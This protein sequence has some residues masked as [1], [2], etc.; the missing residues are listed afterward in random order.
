MNTNASISKRHDPRFND[1]EP[2]SHSGVPTSAEPTGNGFRIVHISD[3]HLSRQFYREH[4][5]SF[6]LLLKS[7]LASGFDH[8][9]ITGDIVST[10]EEDDYYLA[11]EI[12]GTLDLLDSKRL[13]VVP[14]NH[15]IFGGPHRAVD[16]LSFPKYI[17]NVDYA[18]NL[19]LF[20]VAFGET[21]ETTVSYGG[22]SV[23]PFVKKVG[24][25]SIIGLN[26]ILPWSLRRNPLGTNGS[27]DERQR[28]ALV[29][30]RADG[31][32]SGTR[33]LIAM[34]HHFND[35]QEESAGGSMWRRIESRTMRMRGRSKAL[36]LFESLGVRYVLHGHIHRNEIYSKGA[37]TLLNGAGSICDDPVRF[38]KFNEIRNMDSHDEIRTVNLPIPFQLPSFSV[39]IR[40]LNYPIALPPLPSPVE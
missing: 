13:T 18:R 9:I 4:I 3:P 28:D 29:R 27:L 7:L 24:P 17:R 30:M 1:A 33:P 11:R 32:L 5:K 34:H 31:L 37:I 22:D 6:K 19:G 35:L 21:L 38:L 36:R 16:V 14:G 26:S 20:Q 39:P 25:F 8:L 2:E 23:F 15:D 40:K 12:L 10:G